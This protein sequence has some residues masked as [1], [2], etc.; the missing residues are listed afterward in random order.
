MADQ[1]TKRVLAVL[2]LAAALSA[3]GSGNKCKKACKRIEQ[4]HGDAGSSAP[5]CTLS[6]ECSPVEECQAGCIQGASCAAITGADQAG[7][8]AMQACMAQCASKPPSADTAVTLPDSMTMDQGPPVDLPP[9]YPD[10]NFPTPDS[11]PSGP[12]V[13]KFCNDVLLGGNKFTATL[14]VGTGTTFSA[15]SGECQPALNVPCKLIPPGSNTTVEVTDGTQT[16]FSGTFTQEIKQGEE[17]L[18][19]F[20]VNSSSQAELQGG[21]LKPGNKCATTDPFKP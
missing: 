12:P 1:T 11:T 5:P 16:L 15:Y 19:F 17:W 20:T 6:A 8:Q 3:C 7:Q 14:K 9:Q 21:P 4:C 18:F 10:Y 13:G 2:S